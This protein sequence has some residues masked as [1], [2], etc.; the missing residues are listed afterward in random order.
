MAHMVETMFWSGR[1]VPWHGLGKRVVEAPNSREAI[2][3]AG[4]EW[5]VVREPMFTTHH[6]ELMPVPG[7]FANVRE[8]DGKVL[9]VVGNTYKIVQNS[10]AFDFVDGIIGG[11]VRYETAG[12]LH[13]GKKIWLLARLPET[14]IVGDAVVPYLCFT[15][16][17]GYGRN[18]SRYNGTKCRTRYTPYIGVIRSCPK[19]RE[20]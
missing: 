10:D 7:T 5:E 19:N 15:N 12:S 6:S 18:G 14:K 9:G 2:R 16:N 3:H 11:D 20:S 17:I 13:G 8:S 1:E 4:L